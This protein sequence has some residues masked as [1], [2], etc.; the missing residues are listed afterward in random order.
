MLKRSAPV[1]RRKE[2]SW[3]IFFCF[4]WWCKA[5]TRC[6]SR[7]AHD[8]QKALHF[9]LTCLSADPDVWGRIRH[10]IDHPPSTFVLRPGLCL[11]GSST[12][13]IIS[14]KHRAS[15][16]V[17]SLKSSPLIAPIL[18]ALATPPTHHPLLPRPFQKWESRYLVPR[19]LF[20]SSQADFAPEPLFYGQRH[21]SV[22]RGVAPSGLS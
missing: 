18:F 10:M 12:L 6:G 20:S 16:V 2:R 17:L 1:Q 22:T 11:I 8:C 14:R 9:H 7:Q 3:C 4:V 19:V 15:G 13:R 21:N 5:R